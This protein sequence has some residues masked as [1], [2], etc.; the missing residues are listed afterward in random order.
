[1]AGLRRRRHSRRKERVANRGDLRGITL[2][3]VVLFILAH[4]GGVDT[5]A[6]GQGAVTVNGCISWFAKPGA[7]AI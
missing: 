2:A 1:M 5:N 7:C 3:M 6:D 4:L